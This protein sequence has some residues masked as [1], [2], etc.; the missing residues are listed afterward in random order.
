MWYVHNTINRCPVIFVRFDSFSSVF[1]QDLKRKT[2][3]TLKVYY[4]E[5]DFV[6]LFFKKNAERYPNI[7]VIVGTF[8]SSFCGYNMFTQSNNW[9]AYNL[10]NPTNNARITANPGC[11][12]SGLPSIKMEKGFRNA[13]AEPHIRFGILRKPLRYKHGGHS[14]MNLQASKRQSWHTRPRA[15]GADIWSL[16]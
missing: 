10:R 5:P 1:I 9:P 8:H 14:N 13:V 11:S 3:H 16:L 6:I 15:V 2:I 4:N 7:I 12:F